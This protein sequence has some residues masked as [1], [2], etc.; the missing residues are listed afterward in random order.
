MIARLL[1]LFLLSLIVVQSVNADGLFYGM[2]EEMGDTSSSTSSKR[3]E[4]LF[5]TPLSI[6][7]VTAEQIQQSGITTLAEAMKLVPGVIVREQ[8][9]GQFDV[10]IRGLENLVNGGTLTSLNNSKTLIMIDN[11]IVFDYFNGGLYWDTLPVSIEDVERIEVVRGAV[12]S[13]YGA[14][15]VT[16]VIHIFT[17]RA[18]D[19]ASIKTSLIAGSKDSQIIQLAAEKKSRLVDI[20]FSALSE[21]RDRYKDNY[22]S[23]SEDQYLPSDQVVITSAE[24]LQYN[25]EQ[26]VEKQLLMLTLNNDPY[27]LFNYDFTL[28][29]Q[30]SEVQKVHINSRDI[31]FTNNLSNTDG[32][33]LKLNYDSFSSRL[34]HH[35]GKQ[36]TDGF[37]DFTYD[38]EISQASFSY[39][40]KFP[41]WLIQPGVDWYKVKYD[42]LFIGGKREI[43]EANYML[44]MEYNPIRRWRFISAL[45]YSDFN[46]PEDNELNYQFMTTY[47]LSFDSIIRASVQSSSSSPIM[48]KQYIDVEFTFPNDPSQRIDVKGDVDGSL[49]RMTTYE[50]GFR[51]QIDFNDFVEIEFFHNK[52]EDFTNYI[53][54]PPVIVDGQTITARTVQDM[55]QQAI[56]DG[57]TINW[58]YETAVWK[59]NTFL[60]WQNTEVNNQTA[61]LFQGAETFD[62]Y[63]T[64][65]PKY[66][67]GINANWTFSQRI[68]FNILSNYLHE[69]SFEL[70]QPQGT[71][72]IPSAL[73]TNLTLNYQY[74]DK[75]GGFLAIKNLSD[76]HESQ[77]FYT[78]RLEPIYWLG[79]NIK[80]KD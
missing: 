38:T 55:P 33:N 37:P 20:R 45:S 67:A 77:H 15:A 61:T 69:H 11:R 17:K 44:R 47:Q 24:S 32:F 30:K 78:D 22:Y 3:E 36:E 13:L 46:A 71:K 79:F 2:S 50:L 42:G 66:V 21:Q 51:H 27:E 10:H 59:I 72:Y 60:T 7:I 80:F 34:S 6:S 58:L 9:N 40:I 25:T 19:D 64:S 14:N 12:S 35:F 54:Q 49:T 70:Q 63:S 75:M 5:S 16:G 23:F 26:A 29:H 65:T 68:N 28:F 76:Q 56:Q 4:E 18:K 39:Q 43:L 53:I 1:I 73:Y 57:M 74:N 41:Q 8:T 62:E 52:M 48:V 31:P